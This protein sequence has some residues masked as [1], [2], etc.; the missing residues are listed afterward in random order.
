VL[1]VSSGGKEAAVDEQKAAVPR[2][3]VDGRVVD[4]DGQPVAGATVTV[5]GVP[6]AVGS[7]GTFQVR[8]KREVVTA[9]APGYVS[10]RRPVTQGSR[11]ELPLW[12][13][14]ATKP[15]GFMPFKPGPG[16][17]GH[18]LP[19]D[20][21]Y[22]AWKAREYD[23]PTEFIELAGEVNNKMPW[24]CV[25][26]I[27]RA[28]N[29]ESKPLRGSKIAILGVAYKA[30][31]GDVRESP[32]LKIIGLLRERGAVI[33]YHDA[34]VPELPALELASQP[35]EEALADSDC[36]VVLTYHPEVDLEQVVH[37]TPLVV[38]FRGVTR[39]IE[40]GKLARL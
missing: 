37:S 3:Y 32:A 11:V 29:D 22:L 35:L 2:G 9:S 38:D 33:A 17:G 16:L 23:T 10:V 15:Y 20:P 28:L 18:C 24:F 39:G 6:V 26:R 34:H 12:K 19:V 21:F 8:V 31:V 4:A 13:L 25:E 27:A 14:G 1:V 36:A 40:A 30:G 7:D 5:T